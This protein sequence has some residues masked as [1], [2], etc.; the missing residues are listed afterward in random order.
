M[1]IVFT[2]GATRDIVSLTRDDGSSAAF[3]FPHKG[4]TP[5][6]AYHVFVERGLGLSR[7]FWGL[8]A[9]GAG[10]A[11]IG[12]LAAAGGHASASR[13]R[14]PDGDIVELIQAERLVE[15]FEAESW[16]GAADDE[17][18]RSMAAAGWEAS[19]VPPLDLPADVL[20]AVREGIGAFA[21]DWTALACG[22]QLALDWP[23]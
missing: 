12:R 22:G 20:S 1:R 9:G 14:V 15:C 17:G 2:K 11:A 7:G 23:R 5:H 16:S 3:E 6:D 19:H 18:I 10:P 13:A 21:R 4:P 8:V